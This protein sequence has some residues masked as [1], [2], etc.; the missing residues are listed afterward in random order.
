LANSAADFAVS[1]DQGTNGNCGVND[2]LRQS[3]LIPFVAA[4]KGRMSESV[5][6]RNSLW[7]LGGSGV[8][9][10]LQAVYFLLIARA[11]GVE[12]YGAFVGAVSLAA[13]VAPFSSL[14]TGFI[15]IKNVARDRANFAHYWGAAMILT[16]FSGAI[17][18]CLVLLASLGIWSNSLPLRVL[19]LI[20]VSDIIF[21]RVLEL[22]AQ[23]F[24]AIEVLRKNSELYVVLSVARTFAAVV[25]IAAMHSPTAVSWAV[26]YAL[27]A[28]VAM[29]YSIFTVVRTFGMPDLQLRLSLSEFKEGVYFA[30]SQAS[31]TIYND[32]DKTMLV[33]FSGL[34]ATGIY[35]AAYRIVDVSFAPVGALV[36]AAFPRFFRHGEDGISGSA[37]FARRLI[38]YAAGYGTLA[39]SFLYLTSPL[40][41][42]FLGKGF[43]PAALALKWLSPLVLI[44]S[45]HYF[46]ADSLTG[47]GFQGTRTCVQ[48]GVVVINVLLN[49]WLI[50]AYSWRGAAWASIASDGALLLGLTAAITLLRRKPVLRCAEAE[51]MM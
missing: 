39:A 21:V 29:I 34:G 26:L 46:L 1:R 37:R 24:T 25:A 44:K 31:Q 23:A 49:L 17:L 5:L 33:R 9:L 32:I 43:A 8:R 38:P 13:L 40:L 12:Q 6:F 50:P 14:G 16:V 22:S 48:L 20:G 11:L 42:M 27:S 18:V 35:G 10:V 15:L 45:I 30:V 7:F 41:P 2:L 3:R 51:V 47:A 19:L 4:L 28:F 36:Y